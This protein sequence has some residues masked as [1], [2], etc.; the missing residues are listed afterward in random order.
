MRGHLFWFH[1]NR[2][3]FHCYFVSYSLK[4]GKCS[5]PTNSKIEHIGHTKHQYFDTYSIFLFKG[6]FILRKTE[7]F[8]LWHAKQGLIYLFDNPIRVLSL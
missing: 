2:Y 8:F 1:N 7:C 3:T 5:P 4:Q 6:Y